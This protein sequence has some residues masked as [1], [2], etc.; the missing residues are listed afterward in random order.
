MHN[1][2]VLGK[3]IATTFLREIIFFFFG[4]TTMLVIHIYIYLCKYRCDLGETMLKKKTC[5]QEL[6]FEFLQTLA[7]DMLNKLYV[8]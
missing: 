8:C 6:K 2:I 7:L 1:L 4:R 3:S 5:S